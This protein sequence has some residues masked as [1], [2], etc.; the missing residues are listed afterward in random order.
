MLEVRNATVAIEGTTI[1]DGVDLTVAEGTTAAVLG[2]SGSGKS[3]LLR[4]IAGLQR[5]G[6]VWWQGR[7]LTDIPVHERPIGLMFQDYALFPHRSVAGN[8]A[9]GLEMRGHPDPARRVSEVLELVGLAGFEDRDP[10]TLSGGEAQRVALARALAPQPHIL[11]LDEPLGALD[12]TLRDRLLD[13]LEVLLAD[14]DI[15]TVYVTHDHDEARTLADT[16]TIL[17][18]GQVLQTGPTENVWDH[19]VSLTVAHFLGYETTA[20]VTVHDGKWETP[21]GVLA[22]GDLAPGIHEVVIPPHAVRFDA[23][24]PLHGTVVGHRFVG[25][26]A[27][28]RVAG[29]GVEL[30][31]PYD[32]PLPKRG[33]DVAFTFNPGALHHFS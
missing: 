8:V 26:R 5:G 3:T 21:W 15:T 14:L 4:V 25:G 17:D 9:F 28:L 12:R 16:V 6:S 10:G 1:L 20:P 13:R 7:N 2:A 33:D 30:V 11:M 32:G 27:E 22:A 29:G 18:H 31:G 24:G 23:A 19:P